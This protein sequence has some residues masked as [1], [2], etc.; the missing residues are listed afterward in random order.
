MKILYFTC[1]LYGPDS[2]TVS[3]TH[4][5]ALLTHGP[6]A[7]RVDEMDSVEF[8]GCS[9]TLTSERDGPVPG[10]QNGAGRSDRRTLTFAEEGN[11]PDRRRT[12]NDVPGASPPFRV[13][14]MTP[15]VPAARTVLESKAKTV[16][17]DESLCESWGSQLSPPSSVAR[18]AP[19]RSDGP[20]D[21]LFY[22]RH[23]QEVRRCLSFISR[24]VG[25]IDGTKD[26]AVAADGPAHPFINKV[27]T[28]Y[29]LV[30]T[31]VVGAP[32]LAAIGCD[33]YAAPV[34]YCPGGRL[35]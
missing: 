12:P 33:V 35:V 25:R 10:F 7:N 19:S 24:P 21:E 29:E 28:E 31:A 17:R 13:R 1:V 3:G 2:S 6:P 16:R 27:H 8:G 20:T 26:D 4:D 11:V 32:R 9:A 22:E 30:S 23:V 14:K 34:A 15:S 18:M 5:D